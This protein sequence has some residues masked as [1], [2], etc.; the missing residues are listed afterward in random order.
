MKFYKLLCFVISFTFF[1]SSCQK[2]IT[3]NN[4]INVV[5]S[6]KGLALKDVKTENGYFVFQDLSHFMASMREF[7]AKSRT[8]QAEWYSNYSD[9]QSMQGAYNQ[10]L[11]A[12]EQL[13]KKR[14]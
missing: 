3:V 13:R 4:P 12:N 7:N 9:V 2:D 10:M 1:A 5:S 6:D 14:I 11:K 8:E